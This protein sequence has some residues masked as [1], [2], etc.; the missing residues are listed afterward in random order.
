MAD[1]T[2]NN[3]SAWPELPRKK[4]TKANTMQTAIQIKIN[5]IYFLNIP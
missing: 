4:C 1:K 3:S 2:A 5:I